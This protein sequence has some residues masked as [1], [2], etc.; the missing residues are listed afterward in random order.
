MGTDGLRVAEFCAVVKVYDTSVRDFM[1]TTLTKC[2]FSKQ[3][4]GA[5]EDRWREMEIYM[6]RERGGRERGREKV[7]GG[8]A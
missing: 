3:S 8:A 2:H 7:S 4:E 5:S 6:Y 1:L